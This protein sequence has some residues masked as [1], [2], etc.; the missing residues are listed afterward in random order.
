MPK[1]EAIRD[2]KAPVGSMDRLN[3]VLKKK[4]RLVKFMEKQDLEPSPKA[5][6]ALIQ[7]P[8]EDWDDFVL[9]YK[10]HCKQVG[11]GAIQQFLIKRGAALARRLR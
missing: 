11:N 6:G 9:W 4:G 2:K 1:V 3:P 7:L 10:A 8:E 5:L